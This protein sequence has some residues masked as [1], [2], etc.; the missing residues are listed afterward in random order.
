MLLSFVMEFFFDNFAMEVQLPTEYFQIEIDCGQ[1]ESNLN[2]QEKFG[3]YTQEQI[4]PYAAQE[5]VYAAEEE[6]NAVQEGPQ[7]DEAVKNGMDIKYRRIHRKKVN[8][9]FLKQIG[10]GVAISK[11]D[12]IQREFSDLMNRVLNY[13]KT[14]MYLDEKI[15]KY[16]GQL[17]E[18]RHFLHIG[19]GPAH[20]EEHI[21]KV[22]QLLPGWISKLTQ[23]K[24]PGAR[25]ALEAELHSNESNG[26][27]TDI[28]DEDSSDDESDE[29]MDD[30]DPDLE[31]EIASSSSEEEDDMNNGVNEEGDKIPSDI[32]E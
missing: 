20:S 31:Y 25:E 26:E 21:A 23:I 9:Q 22:E 14:V 6:I 1:V 24:A 2:V 11:A 7:E 5:E 16:Q 32:D 12:R 10:F 15:K 30:M 17:V 3:I 19:V 18:H 27:E 28:G 4:E 13:D 8:K 29:E